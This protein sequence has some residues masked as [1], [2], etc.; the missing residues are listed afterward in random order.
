ML[1]A[2]T[3]TRISQAFALIPTSI[4]A[5]HTLGQ[6]GE[7]SKLR[8]PLPT[9][10]NDASTATSRSHGI[11]GTFVYDLCV[12]VYCSPAGKCIAEASLLHR[13]VNR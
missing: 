13:I 8:E 9:S 7:F 10:A 4:L 3:R 6:T 12:G 5:Y 11:I 1:L 2:T